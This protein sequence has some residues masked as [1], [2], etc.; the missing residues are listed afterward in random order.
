MTTSPISSSK[1]GK[2]NVSFEMHEAI[3]K[4][5]QSAHPLDQEY[6]FDPIEYLNNRFPDAD[7]LE[8]IA[9]YT[10][11]LRSEL[12]ELD[13]EILQ[14]I[15]SNAEASQ[16]SSGDLASTHE[17]I[18]ELATRIS[19]IRQRAEES[20]NT[21][22]TVSR[23]IVALDTAKKNVCMTINTLKKL[24]MMVNAC[25]Q[26]AELG[27]SREYAQTPAL[28]LSIK[29][30]EGSFHDI[31][32]IPRVD[33]L[34]KHKERVFTDLKLQ[35]AEDFDLRILQTFPEKR[36]A[37]NG[38]RI[39]SSTEDIEKIDFV[40]AAQAVDA[41]GPEVRTEIINKYC[42]IVMEE[43]ERD[44]SPSGGVFASLEN[45]EKRFQWLTKVLKEFT[46]KH[47]NLFPT[48]WIVNGELCMHF[49]H[50]TR[51]HFIEILP[52]SVKTSKPLGGK[53]G[54]VS[55]PPGPELMVTVLIKCLELERD[56]QRR[57][58][59]LRKKLHND[60]VEHLQFKGV[61]TNCF[62]TYLNVWVSYEEKTLLNMISEVKTKGAKLDDFIGTSLDGKN[63]LRGDSTDSDPPLI[64]ISA[65]NLFAAL[66]AALDRCS[67]FATGKI[68][69]DLFAVFQKV[70]NSYVD[71]VICTRLPK[72]KNLV[73]EETIPMVCALIGSC[74][75][76][77]K[78]TPHLHK[79]CLGLLEK[80]FDVSVYQEIEKLAETRDICQ[81]SLVA[82]ITNNGE[83]RTSVSGIGHMDW[84]QCE[85]ASSVSSHVEKFRVS[86]ETSLAIAGKRLAESH[87]KAVIEMIGQKLIDQINEA[88]YGAKPI[89]EIG[90]QQLLID[91]GEMKGILLEAPSKVFP[92]RQRQATY[93]ELINKGFHRLECSLKALASPASTDKQSLRAML[94]SLDPNLA[95]SG[96]GALEKEV[97]RLLSLRKGP[98]NA[99]TTHVRASMSTLLASQIDFSPKATESPKGSETAKTKPD[100]KADLTKFGQNLM[101]NRL[102]GG[103][104]STQK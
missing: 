55:G 63:D 8:G 53:Q 5:L 44:F 9:D 4:S 30:L 97:D 20:E 95:I 67:H 14:G 21:V 18:S 104:G 46:D 79:N 94:D 32:H 59:K 37:G 54:S 102:F 89:G 34:L 13:N 65:V 82:C 2:V 50:E 69:A 71:S 24:I 72:G 66:R 25:E 86:L 17:A 1:I 12:E 49:C 68:M 45:F 39:V 75:Y 70:I 11:A 48:Q 98:T 19:S 41:L 22:K 64:Y 40:G 77:L 93:Q 28:V 58:D 52:E 91:I 7:S 16:K 84:W 73:V 3:K 76:C 96:P 92:Q 47:S 36:D 103:S 78:M 38:P 31:K 60:T 6:D 33:E 23:D 10:R 27:G 81:E 99:A 43:Y 85:S 83:T 74:D 80:A 88:V 29:D 61:I 87:F 101:K 57:F 42:L 62:D 51:R 100:L 26:L 35:I 56:M 15:R 90:A